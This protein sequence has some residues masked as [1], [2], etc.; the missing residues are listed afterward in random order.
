M[1]EFLMGT[2][3]REAELCSIEVSKINFQ[4]NTIFI[5]GK[6]KKDR[7]IL[8]SDVLKSKIQIYLSNRNNRYLFESNRSTKYSTRRIQQLCAHFRFRA[9][10]N[11]VQLTPHTF[12]HIYNTRLAES[13][14]SKET[15]ALLAGHSNSNTQDIYTHLSVGGLM[16][17]DILKKLSELGL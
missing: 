6:G 12:R 7:L 11:S 17:T 8:M 2:G 4:T 1:F 3:V 10:L 14:V 15:R 16:A 13:G 5:T 9:D